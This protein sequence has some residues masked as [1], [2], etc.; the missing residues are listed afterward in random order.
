LKNIKTKRGRG[1]ILHPCTGK[2]LH[3]PIPLWSIVH[4]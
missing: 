1:I 3:W 2:L 4:S